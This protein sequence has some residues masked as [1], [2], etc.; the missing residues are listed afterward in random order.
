MKFRLS[1]RLLCRHEPT[2][3]LL[4]LFLWNLLKFE[5]V[6]I[7]HCNSH[8]IFPHLIGPVEVAL[9][10]SLQLCASLLGPAF[11]HAFE[12][13]REGLRQ[14]RYSESETQHYIDIRYHSMSL[15]MIRS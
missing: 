6:M 8:D 11:H 9:H 14:V 3:Y 4:T 10:P 15:D 12:P 13:L 1:N 5:M 2:R 7:R